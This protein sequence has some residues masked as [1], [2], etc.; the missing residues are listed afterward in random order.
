MLL[1]NLVAWQ[2]A[3]FGICE[4]YYLACKNYVLFWKL[5]SLHS[6]WEC[7][8]YGYTGR[9]RILNFLNIY[10]QQTPVNGPH[11]SVDNSRL[12]CRVSQ[13]VY[14]N[15]QFAR[16][17]YFGRYYWCH[18]LL[19]TERNQIQNCLDSALS[20]LENWVKANKHMKLN[21]MCHRQWNIFILI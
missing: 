11:Y 2:Y 15:C 3:I 18:E 20:E 16:L 12:W 1:S 9:Y 17:T 14:P 21:Q 8:G 7:G 13:V 5:F 6:Q 4:A 19:H 10:I